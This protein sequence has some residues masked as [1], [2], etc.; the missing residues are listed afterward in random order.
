M[1]RGHHSSRSVLLITL[2][3]SLYNLYITV[4]YEWRL[5]PLMRIK[6][7]HLST[8]SPKGCQVK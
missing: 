3:S 2:K 7:I 1:R 4:L 6:S 8:R 5:E